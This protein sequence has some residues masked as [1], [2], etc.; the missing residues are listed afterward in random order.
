MRVHYSACGD[1]EQSAGILQ[2]S[3]CVPLL[4]S[5]QSASGDT[6]HLSGSEFGGMGMD[7]G[8]EWRGM[9][10]GVASLSVQPPQPPQGEEGGSGSNSSKTLA[11]VQSLQNAGLSKYLQEEAEKV[12]HSFMLRT[13][14][15]HSTVFLLGR[16]SGILSTAR[17]DSRTSHPLLH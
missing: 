13:Q 7:M 4:E 10:A 2:G 9:E 5:L 15:S 3:G 1:G 11:A 8:P 12:C 16:L 17:D 14:L 6:S